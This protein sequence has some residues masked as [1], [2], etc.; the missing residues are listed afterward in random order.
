LQC[1]NDWFVGFVAYE[2]TINKQ[3]SI[4]L[5]QR[6]HIRKKGWRCLL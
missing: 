6:W 2:L 3:M 1:T 4:T 5:T